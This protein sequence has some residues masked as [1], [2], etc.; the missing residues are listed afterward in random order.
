LLHRSTGY[1]QKLNY[2]K[3]TKIQRPKKYKADQ[4]VSKNKKRRNKINSIKS[5]QQEYLDSTHKKWE[6]QTQPDLEQ[7]KVKF[8]GA[9]Q[10]KEMME[11]GRKPKR[12]EKELPI[13]VAR[14]IGDV[15]WWWLA[16]VLLVAG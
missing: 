15:R 6:I 14:V 1:K 13:V 10:W 3:N 8:V 5:T 7:S 4:R 11:M 16:A 12:R 9:V 2:S